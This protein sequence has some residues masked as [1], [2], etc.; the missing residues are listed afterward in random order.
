MHNA[1]VKKWG[2]LKTNVFQ[3]RPEK[4]IFDFLF[5]APQLWQQS[6]WPFIERHGQAHLWVRARPS[7]YFSSTFLLQPPSVPPP[8]CL[9]QQVPFLPY[10]RHFLKPDQWV[11][12]LHISL[13]ASREA[14]YVMNHNLWC[15]A[16]DPDRQT[17]NS[18]HT[19]G[20]TLRD[21]SKHRQIIVTEYYSEK[22]H[23]TGQAHPC[24]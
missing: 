11:T 20:G 12:C 3:T 7:R 2:C 24:P 21:H 19:L 13:L 18:G 1:K 22:I 5:F 17:G 6:I 14:L 10:L 9:H 4:K 23:F 15:A 16:R 8:P